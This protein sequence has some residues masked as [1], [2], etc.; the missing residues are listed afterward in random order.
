MWVSSSTGT[1]STAPSSTWR[2]AYI[3]TS[4]NGWLQ[5][6]LYKLFV[7]LLAIEHLA[8]KILA[9]ELLAVELLAVELLAVEP[10]T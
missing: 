2:V 6:K 1:S 7:E 3:Y 10:E 5:I 8:V 4:A 9:V